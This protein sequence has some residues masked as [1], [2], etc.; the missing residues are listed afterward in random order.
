MLGK[1][2]EAGINWV[3]YGFDRGA[4]GFWRMPPR[5]INWRP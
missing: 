2:K 4:N 3:A 1:M 5:D